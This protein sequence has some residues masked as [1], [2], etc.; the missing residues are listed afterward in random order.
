MC[1]KEDIPS[2][3]AWI[4]TRQW[5]NR[6]NKMYMLMMYVYKIV[7]MKPSDLFIYAS[8]CVMYTCVCICMFVSVCK[9]PDMFICV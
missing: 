8:V 2:W 5:Q 6:M 4:Q 3:E 1:R 7:I 9:H